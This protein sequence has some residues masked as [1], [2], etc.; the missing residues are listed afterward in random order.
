M[1]IMKTAYPSDVVKFFATYNPTEDEAFDIVRA[2]NPKDNENK[3]KKAFLYFIKKFNI[4]AVEDLQERR[5]L[6][7]KVLDNGQDSSKRSKG[8]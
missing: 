7:E 5:R 2:C 3:V 4:Y 8:K 1:A 6:L